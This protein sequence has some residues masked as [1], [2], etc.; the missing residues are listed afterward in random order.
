[1]DRTRLVPSDAGLARR[2]SAARP[3]RLPLPRCLRLLSLT[4]PA[5]AGRDWASRG[6]AARLLPTIDAKSF[7]GA[8]MPDQLIVAVQATMRM[9][10]RWLRSMVDR[11]PDRVTLIDLAER[12]R[13]IAR[14]ATARLELGLALRRAG[15]PA[16]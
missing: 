7:N 11:R 5:L 14:P 1:M 8:D 16:R 3:M 4:L 6:I 15:G 2:G 13:G 10:G 9:S 12:S